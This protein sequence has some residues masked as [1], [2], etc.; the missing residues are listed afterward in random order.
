MVIPWDVEFG[1][2]NLGSYIPLVALA[3]LTLIYIICRNVKMFQNNNNNNKLKII[4]YIYSFFKRKIIICEG[5]IHNLLEH[6]RTFLFG[7]EYSNLFIYLFIYFS[8]YLF[9]YLRSHVLLN[10]LGGITRTREL[11]AQLASLEGPD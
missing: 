7:M 6:S 9:I 11:G 2:S 8:I 3:A 10:P 4:I 5:K 1:N